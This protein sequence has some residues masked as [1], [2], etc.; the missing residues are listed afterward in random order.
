LVVVEFHKYRELPGVIVSG[1]FSPAAAQ[2]VLDRLHL[3]ASLE[4]R[5]GTQTVLKQ[6]TTELHLPVSG[7]HIV[8]CIDPEQHTHNGH[9]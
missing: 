7:I 3:G 8:F 6:I 1:L 5:E 4:R 9:T 2:L